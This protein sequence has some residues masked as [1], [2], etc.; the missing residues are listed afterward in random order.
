[1]LGTKKHDRLT[2]CSSYSC[3][4]GKV[5]QL[6]CLCCILQQVMALSLRSRR[7]G[8][9]T[10]EGSSSP[11]PKERPP[12][13][14]KLAA[15]AQFPGVA[16][17]LVDIDRVLARRERRSLIDA[18]ASSPFTLRRNLA[19]GRKKRK[20]GREPTILLAHEDD[21]GWRRRRPGYQA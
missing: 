21:A 8:A 19:V 20:R 5:A 11:T 17:A 7:G 15:Q 12:R 6:M 13:K 9:A 10:D 3:S 4:A 18:V 16:D 2:K 1:M 14:A